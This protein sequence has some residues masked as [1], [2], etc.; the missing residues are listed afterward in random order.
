MK[1]YSIYFSPRGSTKK[2]CNSLAKH[3]SEFVEVPIDKSPLP[4]LSEDDLVILAMPVFYGRI[5]KYARNILENFQGKGASLVILAVF[6]NRA[7]DD[8]LMEMKLLFSERGFKLLGAGAFVSRHSIMRNVASNRPDEFDFKELELF[9]HALKEKLQTSARDDFEFPG[10][11]PLKPLRENKVFPK[12]DESC[13]NCNICVKECPVGAIP[14]TNPRDTHEDL[15]ISCM[16][17]VEICPV[18]C[19][20]IGEAEENLE[21]RIHDLVI[22]PKK[23]ETYL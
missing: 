17:C 3:F 14:A 19:R 13:I 8:A 9:A 12:G 5:P 6:G 18:L 22:T 15:C 10:N 2:I 20:S 4:D 1:T 11:I 7:Y 21:R 16:R 23:N